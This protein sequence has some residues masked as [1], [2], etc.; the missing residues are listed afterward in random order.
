MFR[1]RRGLSTELFE[2]D[3]STGKVNYEVHKLNSIEDGCWYLCS[4]T[5][6]L[7]IGTTEDGVS[8][9]KRINEHEEVVQTV[10]DVKSTVEEVLLPKVEKEIAPTVTTVK[11]TVEEVILP[12][13]ETIEVPFVDDKIV[14]TTIGNFKVGDNVKNLT[15]NKIFAVLLGFESLDSGETPDEP[16]H[17]HTESDWIIDKDP[18]CTEE[19]SRYKKCSVCDEELE[20]EV[21]S[22]TGHD[23][24]DVVTAPTCT[25]G[26]YTTH[27]CHCGDTYVDSHVDALGHTEILD[28]AVDATCTTAGKTEGK[29]CS[30]CNEVLVAQEE[31]AALGH[32]MVVDVAVAPTCTESGLTEG[33]HCTR[34][35]HVV[36][37][38][39]VSATG[40]T[41]GEVVV[42]NNV[43]PDCIN[44]G[45]YDNVVYCT[46]CEVELSRETI[47]VDSLG[48]S[49]TNYVSNNDATCT[50][51]GTETAKC[52]RCSVTDTRTDVAS[53]LGHTAGEATIENEVDA[54]CTEGG[55]YD[56][57]VYC[58]VCGEEISRETT[59]VN[60]LGH[61]WGEWIVDTEATEEAEGSKHREC[62][63]CDEVEEEIIPKSEP[64]LPEEPKSII[65][66]IIENKTP[67]YQLVAEGELVAVE[68][69]KILTPE[70]EAL[71]VPDCTKPTESGFYE[72][73]NPNTNQIEYGYQQVQVKVKYNP[74]MIALPSY[75]D[76]SNK[77]QVNIIM[78]RELDK[79]WQSTDLQL[80]SDR[81]TIEEICEDAECIIPEV[82]EGYTLWISGSKVASSNTIYRFII[83][84]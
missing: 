41:E 75:I 2:V 65:D 62:D 45:S 17:N 73:K 50:V 37:Q 14:Q 58:A 70:Y 44:N 20:R 30:V 64:E 83:K 55:S 12:K 1:I 43:E 68:Y 66:T 25:E 52:D 51:D 16:E 35:D 76:C 60:A 3:E 72:I 21:I 78:F 54:T 63:N 32:D 15:V 36:A 19:G 22:A 39:I 84:E 18:T 80:T 74:Y 5:A 23:Y 56:T 8:T 53:A 29:H 47:T 69:D 81:D 40:H 79:S 42:E 77:D 26:G 13:V 48:H 31:V 10:T 49:F 6:E 61:T 9:L 27:I 57:V 46:V 38:Q 24:E 82:L 28:D 71:N 33:S 34:C 59:A 7:F 4:D 11:A 67:M